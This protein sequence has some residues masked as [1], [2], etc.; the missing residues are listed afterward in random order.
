[1]K[2]KSNETVTGLKEDPVAIEKIK[3]PSRSES[4]MKV[5]REQRS[6][7]HYDRFQ[8]KRPIREN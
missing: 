8:R 5:E 4:G 2:E 1:M 6:R 7:P 3:L